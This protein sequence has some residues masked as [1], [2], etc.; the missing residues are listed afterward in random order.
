VQKTDESLVKAI[1]D[2]N[3]ELYAEIVKRYQEK[4]IRYARGILNGN[5]SA[6]ED[7]VQ[8]TFIKAYMNLKSFKIDRKFSSWI[9]RITHNEAVNYIKKHKKEIQHDDEEW[10]SKIVDYRPSQADEV[11]KMFS[12]KVV[13]KSLLKLDLKYREPLMLYIYQGSSYEEIGEILKMPIATVGVRIARAKQQLKTIL[14][15]EGINYE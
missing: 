8:E 13:K 5:Q 6:A 12:K 7:V 10:E 1:T 3:K 11:E 15:Q 4:L 9:Y 14:K 2:G